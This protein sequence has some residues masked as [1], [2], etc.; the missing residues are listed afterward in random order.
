VP[1]WQQPNGAPNIDY[2]TGPYNFVHPLPWVQQ[3]TAK[4][5]MLEHIHQQSVPTQPPC[6][7][8]F[9]AN[10]LPSPTSSP[11]PTSRTTN[12]TPASLLRAMQLAPQSTMMAH[13][14]SFP[15]FPTSPM[16]PSR[17]SE[18]SEMSAIRAAILGT[19]YF[20]LQNS[21]A[22]YGY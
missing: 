9:P 1:V 7:N 3:Y 11:P 16:A 4:Q 18:Y 19:L 21:Y 6:T 8:Y 22:V 14:Q 2:N 12:A 10:G 20:S 15:P 17:Y 5:P 13:P